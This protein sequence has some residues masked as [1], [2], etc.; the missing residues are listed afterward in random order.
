[1]GCV[2]FLVVGKI[3][4]GLLM[5]SFGWLGCVIFLGSGEVNL[6]SLTI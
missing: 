6:G 5:I 2:V 1:M 3:D 4:L